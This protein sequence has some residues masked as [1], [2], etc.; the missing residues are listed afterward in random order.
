MWTLWCRRFDTSLSIDSC[1]NCIQLEIHQLE[2][3]CHTEDGSES[4]SLLLF[5][6]NVS[7]HPKCLSNHVVIHLKQELKFTRAMQQ[8]GWN[9]MLSPLM[10]AT[11]HGISSR[12]LQAV[13]RAMSSSVLGLDPR[14]ALLLAVGAGA[15]QSHGCGPEQSGWRRVER[16]PTLVEKTR[17]RRLL[18]NVLS[19]RV[20]D[21]RDRTVH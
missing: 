13:L 10:T 4:A 2:A 3:A 12:T 21:E 17:V 8:C 16:Q 19:A 14:N 11:W 18:D 20:R 9:H 5:L 7:V 15:S 6:E 1:L